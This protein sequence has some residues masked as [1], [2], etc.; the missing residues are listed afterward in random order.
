LCLVCFLCLYSIGLLFVLLSVC[1]C[2]ILH[3]F[4][5]NKDYLYTK[6]YL[7]GCRSN[8]QCDFINRL[9][10]DKVMNMCLCASYFLYD[11]Q[12]GYWNLVTVTFGQGA[13]GSLVRTRRHKRLCSI[14]LYHLVNTDKLGWSNRLSVMAGQIKALKTPGGPLTLDTTENRS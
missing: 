7:T 5:V 3:C 14:G 8:N 6:A 1:L 4:C 13:P 2:F 10:F 11:T 12:S 9:I